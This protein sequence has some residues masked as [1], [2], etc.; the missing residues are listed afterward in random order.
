MENNLFPLSAVH[1]ALRTDP[2]IYEHFLISVSIEEK[3]WV[4]SVI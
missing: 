1:P 4:L 2:T 3:E